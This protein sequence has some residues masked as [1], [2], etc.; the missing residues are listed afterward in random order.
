MQDLF[1]NFQNGGKD[2]GRRDAEGI[3]IRHRALPAQDKHTVD[4]GICTAR[5]IGIDPVS[6]HHRIFPGYAGPF[7]GQFQHGRLRFADDARPLPAGAEDHLADAAAVGDRAE[8]GGTDPVRIRGIVRNIRS[9]GQQ[10]AGILQLPEGQFP[11]KSG[12][13]CVQAWD[14]ARDRRVQDL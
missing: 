10:A 4:P 13:I 3:D 14:C 9:F 2:P 5:D 11:V 12:A 7:H 6:D 1:C 8:F